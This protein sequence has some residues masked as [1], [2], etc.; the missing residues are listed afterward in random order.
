MAVNGINT[1]TKHTDL[2]DEQVAII[3]RKVRLDLNKEQFFDKFYNHKSWQKGAKT[4]EYRKLIRPKIKKEDVKVAVENTA[5]APTAMSY[6]T[7]KVEVNDYRDKIAYTDEA[8]RYN[9]DDVVV[10]ATEQLSYIGKEKLDF[11]KAKPFV[12]SPCTV[13]PETKIVDTMNKAKIILKK[14]RAT[15]WQGNN[16]LMV[17]TPEVLNMLQAELRTLGASIS[18]ATKEQLDMGAIGS[19]NGFLF[20]ETANDYFYKEAKHVIAFVGKNPNGVSPFETYAYN[21]E[22]VEVIH[23]PLGSGILIDEDGNVTSDDNK[24]KGSVAINMKG[25]AAV[26]SNDYCVL[27]C[28]F[29]AT[30]IAGSAIAVS[31]ETGYVSGPTTSPAA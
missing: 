12:S 9:V 31:A 17:T 15:R 20:V 5:P 30:T 28:D 21:A 22:A 7:F 3:E 23:N 24:Q 1:V 27:D 2:T 13:A 10:D 16:Y 25:L 26:V 4:M 29:T 11:I 19:W 14:N 8:V 18:E 6:A